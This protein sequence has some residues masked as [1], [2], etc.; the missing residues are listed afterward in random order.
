MRAWLWNIGA[1][2]YLAV[3]CS[4]APAAADNRGPIIVD[5]FLP[6]GSKLLTTSGACVAAHGT[7][8]V[9][10]AVPAAQ[11]KPDDGGLV[12]VDCF[13]PPDRSKLLTTQAACAK[14]GGSSS[15]VGDGEIAL[16][17]DLTLGQ[18]REA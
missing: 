10:P 15:A 5:C 2:V 8:P 1:V 11:P 13:L 6:D 17:Y 12:I 3:T 16:R 9:V 18:Y 4:V 14:A 7:V